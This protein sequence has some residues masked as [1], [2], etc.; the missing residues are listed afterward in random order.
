MQMRI[1]REATAVS[2]ASALLIGAVLAGGALAQP[3]RTSTA[4]AARKKNALT[5]S[6]TKQIKKLIATAIA[7]NHG[8]AGAKGDPGVAGAV[9][10]AGVKGDDGATGGTGAAGPTGPTGPAIVPEAYTAY[11]ALAVTTASGDD[12]VE[13]LTKTLPAGTYLISGGLNAVAESNTQNHGGILSCVVADASAPSG[14][15]ESGPA[16]QLFTA[17]T[18]QYGGSY[19]GSGSL[20]FAFPF[21]TNASVTIGLY[22]GN[23]SPT[24]DVSFYSQAREAHLSAVPI[25]SVH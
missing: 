20:S 8:P 4:R 17:A 25:S 3:A 21:S 9:G 19:Y 23:Y 16:H 22:C 14:S 15:I 2:V 11:N 10:A 18:L 24:S 7:K 13:Y 12:N 5:S 1:S 6:Q